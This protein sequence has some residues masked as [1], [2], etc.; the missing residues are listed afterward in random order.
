MGATDNLGCTGHDGLGAVGDKGAYNGLGAVGGMGVWKA[1][2]VWT[3]MA[4][5]PRRLGDPTWCIACV[6][7]LL[8]PLTCCE[9]L[10]ENKPG[11][12]L[13]V[14]LPHLFSLHFML[15]PGRPVVIP[16]PA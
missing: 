5:R 10:L 14:A 6:S 15:L 12:P 2:A 9:K 13:H 16:A 4:D 8:T 7:P 1:W 11:L 3:T